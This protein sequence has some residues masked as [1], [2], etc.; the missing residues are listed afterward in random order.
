[1]SLPPTQIQVVL[2]VL[3]LAAAGF[4]LRSRRIPNWLCLLGILLGTGLNLY[5]SQWPGLWLSLE[6]LG[7]ALL[8]YLPLFVLR[9]MGAGDGKLMAAV[10]ACVGPANWFG[11]FVLT[12]VFGSI[13]GLAVAA[14][15]GRFVRIFRNLYLLL[16]SL[17]L[18]RV[19]YASNPELDVNYHDAVRLPHAVSIALGSLTFLFVASKSELLRLW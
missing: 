9:A 5:L 18:G 4:D 8:I 2:V 3:V 10:G 17:R 19:P 6:G 14:A 16:M 1:M 13:L 15:K 7:L 11:V 12:A